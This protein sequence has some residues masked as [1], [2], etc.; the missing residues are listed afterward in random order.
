M[1][2]SSF[3]VKWN[4][5]TL[6]FD[7]LDFGVVREIYGH[8]CYAKPGELKNAKHILDLGA[9]SGSFCVFAA[10]EAPYAQI[11]A[12]E[13]Q[14]HLAQSARCNVLQNHCENQVTVRCAAV[15][16]SHNEWVQTIMKEDPN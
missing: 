4:H 9:N 6:Q 1:L 2:G 13:I 7:Q 11:E 14:S 5:R 16:G 15:G 12:I 10:L 8:L 3:K